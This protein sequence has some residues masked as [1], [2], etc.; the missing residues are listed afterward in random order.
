[1]N[2]ISGLLVSLARMVS[3]GAKLPEQYQNKIADL[4][5]VVAEI[6]SNLKSE[7][8]EIAAEKAVTTPGP[9]IQ[10][11]IKLVT[12]GILGEIDEEIDAFLNNDFESDFDA[13]TFFQSNGTKAM[14]ARAIIE[15]FTKLNDELTAAL[16]KT[17]EELAEGYDCFSKKELTK[18]VEFVS[19]YYCRRS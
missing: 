9:T 18:F 6:G 14:H 4:L 19:G 11:R 2:M 7:R 16:L 5:E 13:Y 17:D 10:E 3:N 12:S 8:Q 1:M 15:D